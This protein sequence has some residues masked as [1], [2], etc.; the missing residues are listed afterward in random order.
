MADGG[1]YGVPRR[2][3]SFPDIQCEV[4]HALYG[5]RRLRGQ[6]VGSQGRRRESGCQASSRTSIITKGVNQEFD[7]A[8]SS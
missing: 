4:E 3:I 5:Q 8:F 7:D 2:Q 6:L 1:V